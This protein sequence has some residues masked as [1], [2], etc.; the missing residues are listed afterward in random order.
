[1]VY[2]MELF[3][4]SYVTKY[5]ELTKANMSALSKQAPTPYLPD[6]DKDYD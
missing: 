2:D 3:F 5:L 6:D 1:M 4:K